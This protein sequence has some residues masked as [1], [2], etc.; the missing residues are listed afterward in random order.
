ME[1]NYSGQYVADRVD[2]YQNAMPDYYLAHVKVSYD[3]T[4]YVKLYVNVRNILDRNY[5]EERYFPMPGRRVFFGLES[6]F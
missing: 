3:A 4:A 2:S 1:I 6:R 5:Q